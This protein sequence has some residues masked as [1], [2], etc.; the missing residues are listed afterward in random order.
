MEDFDRSLHAKQE[1]IGKHF[2]VD[3]SKIDYTEAGYGTAEAW[4]QEF[5]GF[6]DSFYPI[7]EKKCDGTTLNEVKRLQKKEQKVR[8]KKK[9]RPL[10][11]KV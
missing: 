1:D 11:S 2:K 3:W 6:P 5:P 4:A 10:K 8:G 9:I 7:F